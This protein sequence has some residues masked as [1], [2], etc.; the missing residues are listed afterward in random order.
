MVC[1]GIV[2]AHLFAHLYD[3]KNCYC[4]H[5]VKCFQVLI[6]N[7]DNSIQYESFVYSL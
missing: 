5:T 2:R 1:K 4:L 6:S 7:A 3:I